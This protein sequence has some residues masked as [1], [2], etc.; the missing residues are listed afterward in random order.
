MRTTITI[1]IPLFRKIRQMSQRE[2]KTI[3]QVIHELISRGMNTRH[4]RASIPSPF[5]EWRSIKSGALIDYN[6]K[7]A[8]YRALDTD[9]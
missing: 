9:A 4:Q 6:D 8:L 3:T 7:E 5:N 1:D 2:H